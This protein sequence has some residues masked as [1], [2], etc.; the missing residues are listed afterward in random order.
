MGMRQH[1]TRLPFPR[2]LGTLENPRISFGQEV[3]LDEG[4][5]LEHIPLRM[6]REV[7]PGPPEYG[8]VTRWRVPLRGQG[9]T[10]TIGPGKIEESADAL[11]GAPATP[12]FP[13][14]EAVSPWKSRTEG[15]A[16]N[17]GGQGLDMAGGTDAAV[18]HLWAVV[19]WQM[20]S[21]FGQGCPVHPSARYL[22]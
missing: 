20:F 9:L 8:R 18:V 2:F 17:R 22:T 11:R 15:R 13:P 3:R 12:R 6:G 7:A 14:G 5:G 10:R 21:P 16:G 1:L 4:T 19:Q